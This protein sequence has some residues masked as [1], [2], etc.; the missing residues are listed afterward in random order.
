MTLKTKKTT[1]FAHKQVAVGTPFALT[2]ARAIRTHGAKIT[3]FQ[4]TE[5]KRDLDAQGFG[6]TG[7]IHAGPHQM[8]EFDV[9]MAGSGVAGTRPAYGD[10]FLACAM[11]ET[12]VASTSVTYAP[13]SGST[14]VVTMYYE[15]DGQRHSLTDAKGTWSIKVDS[16]A[17][18]YFHFVFTGVW[19]DPATNTAL[20]P[21]FSGFITPRPVAHDYTP[22]VT[23]HTLASVYKSFGFDFGNQVEFFDNP[24][25]QSVEIT[26]RKCSGNVSLIAPVLSTKNYFTT[27]KA[28]TTGNLIMTHGM[29]AGNIV[30]LT[31]GVAQILSPAYGDDKG[32]ATIDAKLDIQITVADD[33]VSLAFT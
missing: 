21:D 27:A 31:S 8:C 23:L 3:P 9:E 2:G 32:R 4:A 5:I 22:K 20:V 33:E 13:A 28:D 29:V 19:N 25:E 26:D 30:T 14:D 16:M 10:L 12:I 18:P 7:T 1:V 6:S 11:S 15:L 24:G 17:I